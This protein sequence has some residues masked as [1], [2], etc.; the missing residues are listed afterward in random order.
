MFPIM[1]AAEQGGP[2]R[3]KRRMVFR[4]GIGP[5]CGRVHTSSDPHQGRFGSG[6]ETTSQAGSRS[7]HWSTT[8]LDGSYSHQ[9]SLRS[10]PEVIVVWLEPNKAGVN[11]P[12]VDSGHGLSL[13]AL[14]MRRNEK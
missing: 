1:H 12:S 3:P 2:L 14:Q 5:R 13:T 10:T 9:T 11:T 6:T 4:T 8:Q 7:L